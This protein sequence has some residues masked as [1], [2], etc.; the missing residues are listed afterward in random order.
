MDRVHI[1]GFSA[2]L[3]SI[4]FFLAGIPTCLKIRR[5]G[6]TKNVEVFPFIACSVS[7]I[8]WLKYGILQQDISVTR[9]NV[10]GLVFQWFYVMV[11][12]MNTL[13]KS[14]VHK[15]FF[16]ASCV[17]F[18]VL[19]YI[20]F[21]VSDHASAVSRLGL[22]CSTTSVVTYG[23]PLASVRQVIKTKSTE[24]MAFP[25]CLANFLVAI[26]WLYYGHLVMDI[27][28]QVPNF[29]GSLLGLFQLAFFVV[30]PSRQ[31]YDLST[32]GTTI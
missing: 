18:P 2:T 23:S 26:Q 24:S 22:I 17:V 28:L 8:F 14:S 11:F 5:Q 20:K 10:I 12:Y 13:E 16:Y 7:C 1:V 19:L 6:S 3:S 31:H 27:Y 21:F 25:L 9:A 30:Y 15:S 32:P 29:F 4:A